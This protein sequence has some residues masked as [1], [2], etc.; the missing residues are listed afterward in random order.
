MTVRLR[1]LES[2]VRHLREAG[3][4]Y[5]EI[6]WRFRRSPG[7]IRRVAAMSELERSPQAVGEGG[8]LRPI[9]RVVRASAERGLSTAEIAARLRRSPDWVRRVE[10]YT[11]YKLAKG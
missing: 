1:P 3:V 5:D 11:S 4:S 9:E 7:F 2:R 10:Q 8:S 6:A